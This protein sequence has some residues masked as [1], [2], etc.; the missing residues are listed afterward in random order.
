MTAPAT[1]H[2]R[3]PA[4]TAKRGPWLRVTPV[5]MQRRGSTTGA[6]R[7]A[8]ADTAAT[9]QVP[10]TIRAVWNA[11]CSA[12]VE[13]A[14]LAGPRTGLW[15]L[16]DR[17]AHAPCAALPCDLG[18][19]DCK[20]ALYQRCLTVGTQYDI[21]SWLNLTDLLRLWHLLVLPAGLKAEWTG[22]LRTAGLL[23]HPD[24]AALCPEL[25]A[26]PQLATTWLR[27]QRRP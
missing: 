1:S 14:R 20:S 19:A 6:A 4:P 26:I 2:Q 22:A 11:D 10:P 8:P 3:P 13:L 5:P 17:L 24:P 16:P 25:I 7:A 27:E 9:S 12:T 23:A 18:R 21:Y 15:R